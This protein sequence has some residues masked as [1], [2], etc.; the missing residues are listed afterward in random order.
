MDKIV[1]ENSP[2]VSVVM[3]VY[4]GS[5]YLK[6]AVESIL[7]QT[8]SNFEF[9]IIND[10]STDNSLNI[11][12]SFSDKRIKLIDNGVNKG[13]IYSLNKGFDEAQGKYIARMDADDISLP[14]RFEKQVNYLERH[15]HVG[16]LGSDYICF[17]EDYSKYILAVHQSEEIKAFLLFGATVC[18]PTLML[19][20]S[21]VDQFHF[22]YSDM[23]K[24]V[25]DFDLWTR[26]SIHTHFAN[27][28]EAL[29]KYRDHPN[30]VSHTYCQIQQEN[31]DLVRKRYLNDLGFDV[32]ESE[33]SVHNLISSNQKIISR[34]DV[35]RIE[36]WLTTLLKQNQSKHSVSEK[37]FGH[38]IAKQW[39]DCCG[40]TSLGLWAYFRFQK[41]FL[42]KFLKQK[43]IFHFK[44]LAK[45]LIR[46]IK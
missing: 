1:K 28:N 4:N 17:T 10:G 13:L 8:Y 27:I 39:L 18:H 16:V 38:V 15:S 40:N 33:L 19:R 12:Q 32:S 7:N 6:E 45:C 31:G 35:L 11:I 14:N 24:H 46:W 9:L 3:S 25:E 44:L 43:S 41:S 36:G 22:R 34:E 29:F 26:M 30:Q 21:V 20:K 5:S 42:K 37:D 2:L 23:A